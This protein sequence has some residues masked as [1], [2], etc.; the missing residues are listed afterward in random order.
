MRD[1]R[2]P[3]LDVVR[4]VA[5]EEL[6]EHECAREGEVQACHWTPPKR[7]QSTHAHLLQ[8]LYNIQQRRFRLRSYPCISRMIHRQT[9]QNRPQ[10]H[11]FYSVKR[12]YDTTGTI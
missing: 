4:G 10:E 1:G 7:S 12:Q 3:E 5:G 8:E 2:G 9:P 6:E 11:N